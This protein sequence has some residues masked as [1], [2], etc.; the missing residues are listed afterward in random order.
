MPWLADLA[1]ASWRTWAA[2]VLPVRVDDDAGDAAG[3]GPAV[4]VLLGRDSRAKG[5]RWSDFVGG[6]EPWDE[7]PEATARREL[8]EETTG[9]VALPPGLLESREALR[10]RDRT[11]GGKDLHRFAVFVSDDAPGPVVVDLGKFVPH[12]EKT[13]LAWFDV[14]E[15]PP[16]RRP[17]EAQVRRDLDVIVPWALSRSKKNG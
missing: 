13:A 3:G 11:P 6:G 8:A 2:G 15:L 9:A 1:A 12:D 14:T 5:G 4:K 7:G 17:F 10:F 16:M